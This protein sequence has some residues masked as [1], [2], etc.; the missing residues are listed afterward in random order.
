MTWLLISGF[1]A[2]VATV[3]MVAVMVRMNV[4]AK[5][6][7]AAKATA[8]D[9]PALEKEYLSQCGLHDY[10]LVEFGCACPDGDPRHVI[11]L[12][13]AEVRRLTGSGDRDD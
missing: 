2:S 12:L 5:V 8:L 4:R 7:T 13:I 3:V 6:P 11:Q 10:G 9:L 1:A